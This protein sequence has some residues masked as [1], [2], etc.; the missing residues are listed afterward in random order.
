MKPPIF[1]S[2]FPGSNLHLIQARV[3]KDLYDAIE[4]E[5]SKTGRSIPELIRE[6]VSF[7]LIP[8]MLKKKISEGRELD[9]KDRE[10]LEAY[11]AY[12]SE[13]T[14]ACSSIAGSHRKIERKKVDRK[15][16]RRMDALIDEKVKGM[17]E[18]AV[19][20]AIK[21]VFEK[22]KGGIK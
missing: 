15:V 1:E 14:E 11:D 16:K 12:L 13:L 6:F 8:E 9:S 3:S 20:R 10:L 19:D 2:A 4:A 7:H 22:R 18:Q 21:K 5:V 17:V